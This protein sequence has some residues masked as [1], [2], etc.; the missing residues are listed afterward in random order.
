MLTIANLFL[1]NILWEQ[2]IL[3][4]KIIYKEPLSLS[5]SVGCIYCYY[6]DLVW[7]FTL[8]VFDTWGRVFVIM[9]SFSLKT[10]WPHVGLIL[11]L[12][13]SWL[14]LLMI[15]AWHII[16]I[17]SHATLQGCKAAILCVV[18]LWKWFF[19]NKERKNK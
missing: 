5:T 7:E 15:L 9:I 11:D 16:R 14:H 12:D 17:L 6:T 2:N 8:K 18:Q 10:D 1:Q 13:L 3:F 4:P 19:L